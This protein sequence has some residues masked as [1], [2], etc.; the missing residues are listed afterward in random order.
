MND[1]LPKFKCLNSLRRLY[2]FR[3]YYCD[4]SKTKTT[5]QRVRTGISEKGHHKLELHQEVGLQERRTKTFVLY[6]S[7]LYLYAR[8][9]HIVSLSH[10]VSIVANGSV[11]VARNQTT[12]EFAGGEFQ[13]FKSCR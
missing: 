4:Y 9:S 8:N 7:Y 6:W 13:F 12:G 11:S 2:K 3:L 10:S 1:K 5:E